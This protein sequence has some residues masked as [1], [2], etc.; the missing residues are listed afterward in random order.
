[1]IQLQKRN[2]G[3]GLGF[4]HLCQEAKMSSVEYLGVRTSVQWMDKDKVGKD[5]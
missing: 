1:M 5:Y 4:G 2:W 3:L